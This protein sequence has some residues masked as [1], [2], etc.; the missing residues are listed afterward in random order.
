M[1]VASLV[2]GMR[3]GGYVGFILT[4]TGDHYSRSCA[5]DPDPPSFCVV[6]GALCLRIIVRTN[7]LVSCS[8]CAGL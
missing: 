6:S 1:H 7:P 5:S 8:L 4:V 3:V 2:G